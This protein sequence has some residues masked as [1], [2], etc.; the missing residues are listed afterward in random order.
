MQTFRNVNTTGCVFICVIPEYFL[1][2]CVNVV[3]VEQISSSRSCSDTVAVLH[4]PPLML[5]RSF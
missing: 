2:S 1:P 4:N 3:N 5:M